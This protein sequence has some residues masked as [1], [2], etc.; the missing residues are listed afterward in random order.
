MGKGISGGICHNVYWHAAA[1]NTC[2]KDYDKYK[3]SF[4]LI[5]CDVNILYRWAM[6]YAELV[7]RQFSIG[8]RNISI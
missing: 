7:F 5:Y 8:W 4:C 6:V 1:N 2:M 3:E